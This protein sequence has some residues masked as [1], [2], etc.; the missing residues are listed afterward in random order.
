MFYM[1]LSS[2]L[3]KMMIGDIFLIYPWIVEFLCSKVLLYFPI[4]HEFYSDISYS[5]LESIFFQWEFLSIH[6]QYWPIGKDCIFHNCFHYFFHLSWY[7]SKFSDVEFPCL[8]LMKHY[9]R[10]HTQWIK[11]NLLPFLFS[12]SPPYPLPLKFCH[13]D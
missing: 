6:I 1:L 5:L 9:K 11:S 8:W 10:L 3:N 12:P 2:C 13:F 4:I 7:K